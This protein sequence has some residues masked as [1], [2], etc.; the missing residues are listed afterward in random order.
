MQLIPITKGD[1]VVQKAG[2]IEGPL[3]KADSK[4]SEHELG[5]RVE[6]DVAVAA[7]IAKQPAL[8]R[9]P[10]HQLRAHCP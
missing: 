2:R 4:H 3:P 10:L 1:N 8:G 9:H 6:H 5:S 7:I